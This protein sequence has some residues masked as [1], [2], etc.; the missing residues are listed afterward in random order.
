M[1]PHPSR[2]PVAETSSPALRSLRITPR[3]R[4]VGMG[5]T[6]VAVIL[7]L[8]FGS[9]PASL[10]LSQMIVA[11]LAVGFAVEAWRWVRRGVRRQAQSELTRKIIEFGGGLYGTI[12]VATWAHLT[13]MDVYSELIAAGSLAGWISTISPGWLI[14]QS[15][16]ALGLGL[17]AA[18]W[19][20]Y[21][22]SGNATW[23][24]AGGVWAIDGIR[25][26]VQRWLAARRPAAAVSPP[27]G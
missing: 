16:Q 4:A 7:F 3:L 12:A 21:W 10:S 23:I 27:A 20:W 25:K 17:K 13:A 24:V 18:L 22:F 26:P 8:N 2:S 11:F 14:E 5:A 19:P 1:T 15:L 9:L 6:V